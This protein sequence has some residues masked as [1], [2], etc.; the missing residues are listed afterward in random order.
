MLQCCAHQWLS[1][2]PLKPPFCFRLHEQVKL[3][4]QTWPQL[5]CLRRQDVTMLRVFFTDVQV[6]HHISHFRMAQTK[7]SESPVSVWHGDIVHSTRSQCGALAISLYF[8]R[9]SVNLGRRG[10]KQHPAKGL[11]QKGFSRS[12][13]IHVQ[14]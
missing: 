10:F 5:Y 8:S 9:M 14:T 1:C 2:L 6:L 12:Q 11:L 3:G 13:K 4:L 7:L